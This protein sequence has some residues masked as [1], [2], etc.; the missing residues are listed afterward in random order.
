MEGED[1]PRV[2]DNLVKFITFTIPT[3]IGQGWWC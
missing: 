3:N 2:Y 1:G